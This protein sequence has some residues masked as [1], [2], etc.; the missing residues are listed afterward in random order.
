MSL[1][2]IVALSFLASLAHGGGG[3][4]KNP[5]HEKKPVPPAKPRMDYGDFVYRSKEGPPVTMI[6]NVTKEGRGMFEIDCG[7]SSFRDGWFPLRREN[8]TD[9]PYDQILHEFSGPEASRRTRW[10]EEIRKKCPQVTL[11]DWDFGSFSVNDGGNAEV[12]FG[13]DYIVLRRQWLALNPGRYLS[14]SSTSDFRMQYDV[15]AEGFVHVKLGCKA[16]DRYPAGETEWKSYQLVRKGPGKPY[17]LTPTTSRD[18]VRDLF[19]SFNRA[20]YVWRESF[21]FSEDFKMVRFATPD[22]MYA[23]GMYPFDRLYR[24][25]FKTV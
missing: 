1:R 9:D 2:F 7:G 14:N 16:A 20:C 21:D 24:H 8:E 4:R 6:F 13:G 5:S 15:Q 11:G 19:D 18:R 12:E 10:L 22:I 17:S 3:T 23:F 25:P